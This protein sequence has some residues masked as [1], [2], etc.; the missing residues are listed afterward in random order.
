MCTCEMV[1][2]VEASYLRRLSGIQCRLLVVDLDVGN[3]TCSWPLMILEVWCHFRRGAL[4]NEVLPRDHIVPGCPC[5]CPCV[6]GIVMCTFHRVHRIW[7][8]LRGRFH[9]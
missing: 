2:L 3:R 7:D 8:S 1:A 6:I 4:A 9:G 5:M